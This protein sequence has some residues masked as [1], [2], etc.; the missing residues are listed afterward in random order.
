MWLTGDNPGRKA[1]ILKNHDVILGRATNGTT[2]S[3]V[4][5]LNGIRL[6]S[7]CFRPANLNGSAERPTYNDNESLALK[8]DEAV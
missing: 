5:C 3:L 2:Y 1:I 6:T 4:C 8:K 7:V